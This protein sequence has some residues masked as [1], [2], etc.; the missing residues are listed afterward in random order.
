M[1]HQVS[2]LLG[3]YFVALFAAGV[4][5]PIG[6]TWLVWVIGAAG[7]LLLGAATI[8]RE[9]ASH[10]KRAQTLVLAAVALTAA[11]FVGGVASATEG[12]FLA[13]AGAGVAVAFITGVATLAL[14]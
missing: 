4:V 6:T 3:I 8:D 14:P 12:W 11:L 10:D 1:V 9:Q 2:A 7:A 13:A 5:R